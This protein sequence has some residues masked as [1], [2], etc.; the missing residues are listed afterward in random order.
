MKRLYALIL[1][2]LTTP[3]MAQ[4]AGKQ[5]APAAGAIGAFTSMTP[6]PDVRAKQW[7]TLV[8][9]KNYGD[10]YTQMSAATRAKTPEGPWE[11]RMMTNR[12][13]LG[14]MASR[15]IKDI[16]MTRLRSGMS[17][18]Q[19]AIVRFDSSFAKRA[20]AVESVTLVSEK[21]AWSVVSYSIN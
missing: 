4:G 15:N 12:G 1:L 19:T 17:D 7:L 6:S 8:D 21:G 9:D 20:A 16:N 3:A 11:G 10:A 2:T 14:A 18:G 13:S 5:P